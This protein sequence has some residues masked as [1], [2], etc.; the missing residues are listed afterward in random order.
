MKISSNTLRTFTTLH[1]WVGLVAG[2]ALFVA[3]YAGA[4]TI[5]HHD[6]QAWQSPHGVNA[7]AQTLDDA[8]RLLDET[9]ERH[10]ESRKHVG[11]VFPG[12]EY[13]ITATY[14][15]DAKGAWR[16]ATTEHPEGLNEMP[17]GALSELVN[18]LHYSLG[19]PVAGTY[20]MGI[21]SLLYGLALIS[22]VIIHLP[23]LVED[24]FALRPGRNLKRMWQDAHN[25]IGVLSLPMHIM[26]AVTGA[27]LCL[28]MIAM[29]ALNPLIYRGQL[30]SALGP[31]MDTAPV[32]A[33]ANREQALGSLAMWRERSIAIA[34]EQGVASFEPAYLKL[35]NVGDANATIEITGASPGSLGPLGA[36]A[37][38]A[39]TGAKL[40]TQLP[41][42]R[43]A[44]HATLS[45][46][47]ALHFG[48]Y[49]NHWV[50]WLYFLLG[51]GGAFLFYSGNL[52]WIES[53]RKRRQAE[54]GRAQLW[55][56][57]ATVGVCIGVCVAI[58]VA[59]IATQLLQAPAFAAVELGFGVNFACF[60]AWGLCALWAALRPPIR[61]AQELLWAAA[62]TTA[63]I[64][65]AHGAVTGAWWWAS[66]AAG[67]WALFAIDAG[68]IAM[69]VGFAWL[70]RVTARRMREGEANSVWSA[71]PAPV[72]S[73]VQAPQA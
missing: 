32:V 53:R 2:F 28:A 51:L 26:F 13:P 29:F 9:L 57:R 7:K 22:G 17:G 10:P 33:P 61:A 73:R 70:A 40:A 15:Q 65:V 5:F 41:G 23:K 59:F 52:L 24:L 39:N 44:N 21:V 60:V 43:D 4:I 71:S 46:A 16:Y 64:P 47:Y 8:Q 63:L 50:Q 12:E 56:A 45:S 66:A 34:N 69:A 48:E 11:M 20:L 68:A 37:M 18:A 30:M 38:N 36:V 1:T 3:F 27:M 6:L 42:Q 31:A 54:Q 58:S 19:I 14:W 25:V 67:Q 55:M 49:G 62:V 35:S 72:A